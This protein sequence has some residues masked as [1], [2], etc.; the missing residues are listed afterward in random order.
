MI[1]TKGTAELSKAIQYYIFE[2]TIN[3]DWLK[4]MDLHEYEVTFS[5]FPKW[6]GT[7]DGQYIES[8]IEKVIDILVEQG[9]LTEND[10]DLLL[11]MKVRSSRITYVKLSD[12]KHHDTWISV[13]N[14]ET[15]RE[16]YLM[17]KKQNDF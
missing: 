12:G 1:D 15:F 10:W 14:P 13:I 3:I 5:N 8:D 4:D 16:R 7:P 9:G 2:H 11:S 17:L 6:R